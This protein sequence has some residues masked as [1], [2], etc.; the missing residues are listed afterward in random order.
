M[1]FCSIALI[2]YLLISFIFCWFFSKPQ[3]LTFFSLIFLV[4]EKNCYENF[5]CFVSIF[6]FFIIQVSQIF[7]FYLFIFLPFFHTTTTLFVVF[8]FF[9]PKGLCVYD[10]YDFYSLRNSLVKHR[11][12]V[13]SPRIL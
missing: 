13:H 7:L 6:F 2:N 12:H 3:F 5:F 8:F 10:F 9:F 1:I 4:L 11:Q